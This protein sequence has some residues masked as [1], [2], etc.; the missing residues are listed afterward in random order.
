MA[1]IGGDSYSV[2]KTVDSDPQ[3][4]ILGNKNDYIQDSTNNKVYKSLGGTDWIL[5]SDNNTPLEPLNYKL[6]SDFKNIQKSYNGQ[7]YYVSERDAN[8]EI[9]SDLEKTVK[10]SSGPSSVT[11]FYVGAIN[12]GDWVIGESVTIRIRVPKQATQPSSGYYQFSFGSTFDYGFGFKSLTSGVSVSTNRP[13]HIVIDHVKNDNGDILDSPYQHDAFINITATLLVNA[14]QANFRLG[15]YMYPNDVVE[16]ESFKV[17][18]ETFLMQEGSGDTLTGDNGSVLT[19]ANVGT[20]E[21]ISVEPD[22]LFQYAIGD[23]LANII[24]NDNTLTPQMLGYKA[25]NINRYDEN[26]VSDIINAIEQ[27]NFSLRIPNGRYC[28]DKP[29][30]LYNPQSHYLSYG[31]HQADDDTFNSVKQSSVEFYSHKKIPFFRIFRSGIN[32]RGG[33][34]NAKLIPYANEYDD[35][36]SFPT[37]GLDRYV[38]LALDSGLYYYWDGSSYQTDTQDNV[39]QITKEAIFRICYRDDHILDS[40][41]LRVRMEGN[42]ASILQQGGGYDGVLIDSTTQNP[43]GGRRI[44]AGEYHWCEYELYGVG[45]DVVFRAS[46]DPM[47]NPSYP[48]SNSMHDKINVRSWKCKQAVVLN[49]MCSFSDL[50]V[51]IQGVTAYSLAEY[52][53]EKRNTAIYLN[54]SNCTVEAQIVDMNQE[55]ATHY[56]TRYSLTNLIEKNILVGNWISPKAWLNEVVPLETN[57]FKLNNPDIRIIKGTRDITGFHSSVDNVFA[58][59]IRKGITAVST[60]YINNDGT[61]DFETNLLEASNYI[62]VGSGDVTVDITPN[63]S[64]TN[65]DRI[66]DPE[67]LRAMRITYTTGF[68]LANDDFIEIVLGN[69]GI[70]KMKFIG[71]WLA[72]TFSTNK[73]Y[74]NKIQIIVESAGVTSGRKI[75]TKFDSSSTILDLTLQATTLS[76]IIIR[77]IGVVDNDNKH[78]DISGFFG[79]SAVYV[80][81]NECSINVYGNQQIYGDLEV[82]TLSIQ[83]NIQANSTAV[84]VATIVSD[85]NTFLAQYR[86]THNQ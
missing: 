2:L 57:D 31:R 59:A 3:G 78:I 5:I 54:T 18:G 25:T 47:I 58:K 75:Y 44:D 37:E 53:D 24:T 69:V 22:E 23:K 61:F 76:K 35:L 29:I 26:Y 34:F 81:E 77:I 79:Q 51:Q 10:L 8:Y 33:Y 7:Q 46:N 13:Q 20:K 49:G 66:F 4:T 43:Y 67:D 62:G 52:N 70:S 11:G 17:R 1:Q 63:V 38:Y 16:V 68:S 42:E 32:I 73:T 50:K 84:D 40:S 36:A 82:D 85:F 39:Q 6:F 83:E 65:T 64:I 48:K 9:I 72:E 15:A 12:G 27:S 41:I 21:W 28:L 14:S 30:D 55:N 60:S 19:Y 86:T 45:L 71:F 56:G 80:T 74:P